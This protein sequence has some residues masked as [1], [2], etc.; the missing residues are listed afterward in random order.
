MRL[1]LLIV[2]AL[3]LVGAGAFLFT[4]RT[5]T[6]QIESSFSVEYASDLKFPCGALTRPESVATFGITNQTVSTVLGTNDFSQRI[7]V[8]S[9]LPI[10]QL[11]RWRGSEM[12]FLV[13][14]KAAA[15]QKLYFAAIRSV[16]CSSVKIVNEQE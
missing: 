1:I 13:P 14:S 15:D 9:S 4:N 6:L 7:W 16:S 5:E 3:I 11:K 10:K 2:G 12:I 8:F